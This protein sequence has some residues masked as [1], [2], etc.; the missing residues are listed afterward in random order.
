LDARS[1]WIA[2]RGLLSGVLTV[3]VLTVGNARRPI[4]RTREKPRAAQ[5]VV[6]PHER[7][8]CHVLACAVGFVTQAGAASARSGQ[9]SQLAR[10]A[11]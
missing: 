10:Q 8:R 2:L 5:R 1:I 9:E 7:E 4:D 6:G 11:G 3:E